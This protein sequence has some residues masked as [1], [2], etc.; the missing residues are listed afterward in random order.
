MRLCADCDGEQKKKR[1]NKTERNYLLFPGIQC[2]WVCESHFSLPWEA[3]TALSWCL[4]HILEGAS[5]CL[6]RSLSIDFKIVFIDP[7]GKFQ[8]TED[9]CGSPY[10]IMF[11]RSIDYIHGMSRFPIPISRASRFYITPSR[12]QNYTPVSNHLTFFLR[13]RS[14]MNIVIVRRTWTTF[15]LKIQAILAISGACTPVA[16]R[17]SMCIK[18]FA[19]PK[20]IARPGGQGREQTSDTCTYLLFDWKPNLDKIDRFIQLSYNK[21]VLG[22]YLLC[23]GTAPK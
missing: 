22:T 19:K 12:I 7:L 20:R 1:K 13:Q 18:Q 16:R 10:S 3:Q 5:F 14:Q 8:R 23:M 15:N 2:P 4:S 17:L 6:P 11:Y 9:A 21:N